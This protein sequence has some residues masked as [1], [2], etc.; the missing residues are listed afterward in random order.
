MLLCTA[1]YETSPRGI[2]EIPLIPTKLI[3]WYPHD[4]KVRYWDNVGHKKIYLI[5]VFRWNLIHRPWFAEK[6]KK[7]S[8][9]IFISSVKVLI[10]AFSIT[11]SS[12]SLPAK[13]WSE[14]YLQANSKMPGENCMTC[15]NTY[16]TG[17]FSSRTI[18]NPLLHCSLD[19]NKTQIHQEK[20]PTF[21]KETVNFPKERK[22]FF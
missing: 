12:W 3:P 14:T 7:K 16:Y 8:L 5:T 2:S 20:I 17:I 15:K 11:K 19:Q 10:C 21:P 22:L 18:E 1:V 13:Q 9:R 4:L 6:K